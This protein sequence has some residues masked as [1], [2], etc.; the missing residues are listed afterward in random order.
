MLDD[1][2]PRELAVWGTVVDP[3]G[4]CEAKLAGGELTL[5]VPATPHNLNPKLG[6]L[7]GVRVQRP[8]AGDFTAKVK[9][10]GKFQP[11]A[12]KTSPTGAVPF[13]GAGLLLWSDRDHF[14]RLER[15]AWLI[16][17]G[18]RVCSP[19]LFEAVAG[20]EVH[21]LNKPG[22][23]AADFLGGGDVWLRLDRHGNTLT[24]RFSRDGTDWETAGEFTLELPTKVQIGPSAVNTSDARF[25]ATFSGF[26]V[27]ADD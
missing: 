8:I 11:G 7:N 2:K 20:G 22:V 1:P 16:P 19:P 17:D 6:R 24:A 5:T 21:D 25:P 13:V 26:K 27:V 9:V 3:D 10:S 15:C 14:V 4:D 23:L 12:R 18:R